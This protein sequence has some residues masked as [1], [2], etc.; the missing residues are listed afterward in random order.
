MLRNYIKTTWVPFAESQI[1]EQ[2]SKLEESLTE[3]GQDP[4]QFGVFN[5]AMVSFTSS[6]SL[7]F[8][9]NRQ[10]DSPLITKITDTIKEALSKYQPLLKARLS[11]LQAAKQW[12][13]QKRATTTI[14][15]NTLD[16]CIDLLLKSALDT[17]NHSNVA[18]KLERF[19]NLSLCIQKWLQELVA[20]L[21]KKAIQRIETELPIYFV[22]NNFAYVYLLT[23]IF[24]EEIA[25]EI[26]ALVISDKTYAGVRAVATTLIGRGADIDKYLVT[27]ADFFASKRTQLNSQLQNLQEALKSVHDLKNIWKN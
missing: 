7:S 27:E 11:H 4:Q 18:I 17:M 15:H 26:D 5:N 20:P 23:E 21:K 3:L 25:L 6:W 8:H 2:I 1:S 10:W 9:T 19:E 24:L 13:M 12:K 14:F 22:T 16:T